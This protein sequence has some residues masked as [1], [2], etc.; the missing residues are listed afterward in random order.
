MP[1]EKNPLAPEGFSSGQG[2]SQGVVV[3]TVGFFI[4]LY[5]NQTK[6]GSKMAN[7]NLQLPIVITS[8]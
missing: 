2:F 1:Y 5:P 4:K 7:I 6:T 3:S 8:F